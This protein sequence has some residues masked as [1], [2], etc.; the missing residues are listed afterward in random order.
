MRR[1]GNHA[2][3]HLIDATRYAIRITNV[4][5]FTSPPIFTCSMV[6]ATLMTT[7]A[8]AAPLYKANNSDSLNAT[9]SWS[10]TS[11]SQTPNPSSFDVSDV[12][13]FNDLTMLGSKTVALGGDMTIAGI[14][15]DNT[16]GTSTNVYN[17][18]ITA[19]NTLT[20]NG[21][22]ISGTGVSGGSGYN[23]AGIVLNRATGGSLTINADVALGA[24]QQWVTSRALTVGG[25]LNLN[26]NTLSFN[27]AGTSVQSLNGVI[28]GSGSL[29]KTAGNGTLALGNADNTFSGSVT[30]VAGNTTVTKLANGG[31]SSSLGN[32]SSAI[33][34]NGA[35][36]T[37]VGSA[38]ASTDRALDMRA[39]VAIQNNSN[40]GAV[41]FTAANVIQGGT[42]SAR[43][44]TL[45]GSHA[46]DNT[47][48][49]ILGNSGTG[50]NIS[51]LQ[52]NG[53]GKWIITGAQTYTGSTTINQGILAVSG[54]T[55]LGGASGST[56]ATS[57]IV[58]GQNLN[59]GAL[60]FESTSNLGAADQI[61]FS[62]T[63]GTNGQGGALVYTGE[64][65]QTLNKTLYCDTSIGI[66]VE[67][68]STSGSLN[69]NGTFSQT[70]RSLYLG[71]TGAG[72]NTLTS[73]FAGTGSL[74]KRDGGKWVI[75]GTQTY[76]GATTVSA[77]TLL[78]T[79]AL[80]NSAVNVSNTGTAF[81]G[82]GSMS[83]SLTLNVGSLL[84]VADLS[85]P[86]LVTGTINL[87]SGF[88][89]DNLTG[90]TWSSVSNGTYTLLDGTLGA[91]VF[92]SLSH[93][94]LGSAYD[95]GGGRS[96]YFQQGSLQLVVVPE[97]STTLLGGLGLLAML[98]RRRVKA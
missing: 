20:L 37:Y 96:A 49:S 61:R 22:S 38:S 29:N 67:S 73:T 28:S 90:L 59:S 55:V 82:T 10:T 33:I 5:K 35:T 84:Y 23:T 95:I 92:D 34:M 69:L 1:R 50:A 72:N 15:L 40:A 17:V 6:A 65:N 32:G 31:N 91:G 39:N 2:N 98:R 13:Y 8:F 19:G 18:V 12:M 88:G 46:G 86:L 52:K 76:T 79:G 68:N 64:T 25:N 57:N 83:G 58:F 16:I 74:T 80:G 42:A 45:A 56:S 66:R 97:T 24:S 43:T 9:T 14:A 81:G 70:N 62:N 4:M 75:G 94:S 89:V 60:H 7:C 78:V 47:W 51:S 87:Y 71:G 27:T 85:D 30:L 63:G 21:G 53:A 77:G 11:G 26:A 36:L 3:Y 44:L 93:N 41:T 48:N 54:S